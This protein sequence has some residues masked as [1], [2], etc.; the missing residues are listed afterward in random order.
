MKTKMIRIGM[1]I[2]VLIFCGFMSGCI[3][4]GEFDVSYPIVVAVDDSS[5]TFHLLSDGT[6]D[7]R[8]RGAPSPAIWEIVE[9]S[10]DTITYYIRIFKKDPVAIV[11]DDDHIASLAIGGKPV[12][13][14]W[15]RA[16]LYPYYY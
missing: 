5:M 15:K 12:T 11:I 2:A 10:N 7:V 1:V 6:A 14:T 8:Y 13:G 16:Y 9:R 4:D 3:D